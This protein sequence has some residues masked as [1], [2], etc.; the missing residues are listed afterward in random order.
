MSDGLEAL[1]RFL[2]EKIGLSIDV[3]RQPAIESRLAPVIAECG[4]TSLPHLVARL[5]AGTD[6]RLADRVID[7][8]VTC[9]TLFFRDR[10]PFEA[11]RTIVLPALAEKRRDM[12]RLRIWSAA[13]ATGQEPYSIAM[14]LD[15]M[16]RSFL[17]WR[18]DL[19]ASDIS[20]GALAS[21]EAGRY[22]QF[23]VQRGLSTPMLLRHF[24]QSDGAWI[25]NEHLKTAVE[26]RNVNLLTDFS[27]LGRFDVVLCRNAL[28]YMDVARRRHILARIA[29]QMPD[30]GYLMLGA[31]ETLVNLSDDF[32][33]EPGYPGLFRRVPA[34][35][36]RLRLVGS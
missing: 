23:E 9:E 10:H 35:A 4:A 21:A 34:E 30:D 5:T 16:S 20:K 17:G 27:A 28:M 31:A 11:M 2:S 7:A 26:F 6:A 32:A 18:I 33:P 25:I 29:R 24:R 8:M 1:A 22:S 36:P 14:L 15:E 19:I 12:R 3:R 13:C